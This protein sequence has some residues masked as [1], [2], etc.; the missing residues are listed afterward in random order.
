[1][2][3]INVSSLIYRDEYD[4]DASIEDENKPLTQ[5]DLRNRLAKRVVSMYVCSC[6]TLGLTIISCLLKQLVQK[7]KLA[8]ISSDS[9]PPTTAPGT[10]ALSTRSGRGTSVK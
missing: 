9:H 6:V 1:M 4:S 5:E 7:E 10:T 3:L 2:Q 8:G